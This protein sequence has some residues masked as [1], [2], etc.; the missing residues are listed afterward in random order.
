MPS[1]QIL[2]VYTHAPGHGI[3]LPAIKADVDSDSASERTY[4]RR[5]RMGGIFAEADLFWYVL[6]GHRRK[7]EV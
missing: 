4:S 2:S 7:R 6:L 1:L 3:P 5:E